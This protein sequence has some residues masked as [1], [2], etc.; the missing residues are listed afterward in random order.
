[1]VVYD[2]DFM[3]VLIDP[4]KA[5]APLVVDADAVLAAAV[6]LEGFQA[7]AGRETHDVESV[8]GIE[9]EK[10]SSG[11]ALDIGWQVTRGGAGKEL[12]GFGVGEASNHGRQL[13]RSG[14]GRKSNSYAGRNG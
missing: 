14:D 10:L 11:R 4:T 7:V 5:D 12:F 13:R 3:G 8:G 1:M 9:L 6:T 2:F